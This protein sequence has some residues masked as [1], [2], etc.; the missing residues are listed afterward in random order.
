MSLPS[1]VLTSADKYRMLGDGAVS[2]ALG[3]GTS[4]QVRLFTSDGTSRTVS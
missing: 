4:S 1:G 2:L 3:G